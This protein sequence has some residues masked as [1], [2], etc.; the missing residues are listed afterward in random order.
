MCGFFGLIF[1]LETFPRSSFETV[2]RRRKKSCCISR[3]ILTYKLDAP[4]TNSK[5]VF[6]V[7]QTS[8]KFIF[9][10]IFAGIMRTKCYVS[11]PRKISKCKGTLLVI[12]GLF[13]W[14]LQTKNTSTFYC[15]TYENISVPTFLYHIE[16]NNAPLA[17]FH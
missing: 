11:L 12:Y 9:A 16:W 15:V 6:V 10:Q 17:T 5:M 13:E 8:S 2:Q 14:V 1:L 3:S 7:I 4:T